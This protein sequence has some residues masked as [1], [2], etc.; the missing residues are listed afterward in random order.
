MCLFVNLR[1]RHD[2]DLSSAQT[3]SEPGT[4]PYGYS[5]MCDIVPIGEK[6][7]WNTNKKIIS[8]AL[9][10][11]GSADDADMFRWYFNGALHNIQGARLYYPDWIVRLHVFGLNKSTER[12]L[13]ES[14]DNVEL[15]R[16]SLQ[17]TLAKSPS[18][19]MMARFLSYDDPK[20]SHVISRDLDSRFS[21]R[22]LFAVNQWLSSGAR[23]HT[24]RDHS[25]H[26]VPILGGMFG[27]RR[28]ALQSKYAS[29]TSLITSA[30]NDNPHGLSGAPGEDQSF[31]LNYV[32][33]VVVGEALAHDSSMKRC[34]GYGA[35][36]CLEFPLSNS[37]AEPQVFVGQ[38]FKPSDQLS[39]TVEKSQ[40]KCSMS[41]Y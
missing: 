24:M 9:F 37:E 3:V 11:S 32:W 7:V 8:F 34:N 33:P 41:C 29:M 16:C 19:K 36:A 5:E 23:F 18:R 30:F 35:L 20:V 31:L 1:F 10:H 2:L 38:A 12:E 27:I 4:F 6:Q 40:Y 14:R 39:T 15:V 21:P 25:H 13:L 17:S 26:N 22:E 28:G